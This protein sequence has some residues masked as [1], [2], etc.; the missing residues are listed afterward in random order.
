MVS[1]GGIGA[2]VEPVEVTREM[3]LAMPPGEVFV[4]RWPEPL[5]FRYFR[6]VLPDVPLTMCQRCFRMYHADEFELAVLQKGRC[7]FC[8]CK[9]CLGS[10]SRAHPTNH[11]PDCTPLSLLHCA[12][13]WLSILSRAPLAVAVI[14]ARTALPFLAVFHA[15]TDGLCLFN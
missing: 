10:M 6:S 12:R 5:S 13:I 15:P 14:L 4:E 3:L 2:D 7:P 8:R 11:Q 1:A 9:V